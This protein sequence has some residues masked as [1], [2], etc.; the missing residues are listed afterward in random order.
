[1]IQ[2]PMQAQHACQTNEQQLLLGEKY[3]TDTAATTSYKHQPVAA[4]KEGDWL[5]VA[6]GSREQHSF[7]LQQSSRSVTD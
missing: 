5:W 3:K 7:C 6:A 2:S 1:M 4:D